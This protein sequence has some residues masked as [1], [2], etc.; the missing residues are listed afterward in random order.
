MVNILIVEDEDDNRSSLRKQLQRLGHDVLEAASGRA[1]FELFVQ[2]KDVLDLIITDFKMDEMG[3]EKLVAL[4]RALDPIIPVIGISAHG[5]TKTTILG[6][7]AYFFLE[8]PLPAS[9]VIGRLIENAIRQHRRD[10]SERE[11]TRLLRGFIRSHSERRLGETPVELAIEQIDIPK[12][13]GDIAEAIPLADGR[14]LFYIADA[15]GHDSWAPC[16]AACLLSIIIHRSHTEKQNLELPKLVGLADDHIRKILSWVAM[17]RLYLTLFLGI[18]DCRQNKLIFINAGH[19]PAI[20][21]RAGGASVETLASTTR[22]VGSTIPIDTSR[23]DIVREAPYCPGD[24]LFLYTDGASELLGQDSKTEGVEKLVE[25]VELL[26]S[27]SAKEMV[28]EVR[29]YLFREAGG[30][31][32]FK[33]DTTLMMLRFKPEA[34]AV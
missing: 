9:A 2:K 32:G 13:S 6:S 28:D 25:F 12:P 29:Q 26:D 8:K 15:S 14:I 22:P 31:G 11:G 5:D 19:D 24:V 16:L 7:G 1:G 17:D 21:Y 18:L 4:I 20:L 27:G 30:I 33:D 23:E 3:G 34:T 10:K